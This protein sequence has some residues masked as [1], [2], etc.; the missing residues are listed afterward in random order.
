MLEMRSNG[1]GMKVD[2]ELSYI[3]YYDECWVGRRGGAVSW[4]GKVMDIT[5]EKAILNIRNSEISFQKTIL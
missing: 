3:Q 2:T 4:R 1:E 5:V